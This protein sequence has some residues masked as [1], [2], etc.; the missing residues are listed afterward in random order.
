MSKI[1][2]V[3]VI[4]DEIKAVDYLSEMIKETPGLELIG[5]FIN[6]LKAL[7]LL[8][9]DPDILVF[10]DINMSEI[11]GLN[12]TKHISNKVIFTT[13]FRE[14]AADSYEYEKTVDYLLKPIYKERFLKAVKKVQK[15]KMAENFVP[16]QEYLT[17]DSKEQ[18]LIIDY[19]SIDYIRASGHSSLVFATEAEEPIIT[20]FGLKKIE[21]MLPNGM[22]VRIH[23][24]YLV[25]RKKIAHIK[26]DEI[27][28]FGGIWLPLG[29]A[30]VQNLL[31]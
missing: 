31:N 29:K 25:N 20:I 2:K 23:K 5:Y 15:L 19:G 3:V 10:L 11:S 27:M 4:D 22:F 9:Q 7:P 26:G 18:Q 12:F 14:Y 24:Q 1:I 28:L 30:F 8:N 16:D 13:A 17:L 21:T 6:P